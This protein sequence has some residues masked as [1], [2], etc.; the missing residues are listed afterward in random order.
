MIRAQFTRTQGPAP[1]AVASIE[2]GVASV[3]CAGSNVGMFVA[4]ISY[5]HCAHPEGRLLADEK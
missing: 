2:K 3:A 5:W 1:I 4:P